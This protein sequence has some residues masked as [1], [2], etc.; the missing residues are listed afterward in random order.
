MHTVPATVITPP[1]DDHRT[2]LEVAAD[3]TATLNHFNW[4]DLAPF[5]REKTFPNGDSADFRVFYAGRDDLHGILKFLL[6]RCS[7][8]LRMNMFGYDD[9]ELD[10]IIKGLVRNG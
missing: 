6:S 7:R 8:S 9:D 5:T 10:T 1:S 4:L 2:M 3:P